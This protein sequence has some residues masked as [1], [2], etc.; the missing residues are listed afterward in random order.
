M[1]SRRRKP[2]LP[3]YVVVINLGSSGP[4]VTLHAIDGGADPTPTLRWLHFQIYGIDL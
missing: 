3:P 2:R 4:G 1:T